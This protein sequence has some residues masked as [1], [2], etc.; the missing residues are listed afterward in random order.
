MMAAKRIV[1][2]LLIPVLVTACNENDFKLAIKPDTSKVIDIPSDPV[3]SG[4]QPSG[5]S[6]GGSVGSTD[7]SGSGSSSGG[8]SSGGSVGST[9]QDIEQPIGCTLQTLANA[10]ALDDLLRSARFENHEDR[11]RG[12]EKGSGHESS[13]VSDGDDNRDRDPGRGHF[14]E[15]LPNRTVILGA[16]CREGGKYIVLR[17]AMEMEAFFWVAEG[18]ACRLNETGCLTGGGFGA[19]LLELKILASHLENPEKFVLNLKECANRR[20]VDREGLR[21]YC[22]LANGESVKDLL[23]VLDLWFG[24]IKQLDQK[25][26][27]KMP[28]LVR[29]VNNQLR[30][31]S[32]R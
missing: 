16:A 19:E 32:Y 29:K 28:S 10:Q 4:D 5:G 30:L 15:H 18:R 22:E 21:A 9:S 20:S 8:G 6:A 1:P 11:R 3:G 25:A 27:R 24:G 2:L 14:E 7:S 13:C 17:G 12:H 31:K 23:E 26:A